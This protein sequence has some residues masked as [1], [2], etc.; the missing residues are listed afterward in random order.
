MKKSYI[1]YVAGCDIPENKSALK[2]VFSIKLNE[3][4]GIYYIRY[5]FTCKENKIYSKFNLFL[6]IHIMRSKALVFG[7]KNINLYLKNDKKITSPI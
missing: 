1:Q 4:S 3:I 2:I 5:I 6:L 7:N